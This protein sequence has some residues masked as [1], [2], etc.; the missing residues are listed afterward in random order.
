M[1]ITH[2][3]GTNYDLYPD[4]DIELTRYNPFFNDLGEQSIPVSIPASAKNLQLFGYP[5]RADNINKIASRLDVN[6]QSG[7]F[8]VNGR[9]AILSAQEKGSIETSFYLHDGAFYEKIEDITLSEIF[10]DRKITFNNIDEA[11]SFMYS[12]ISGVDLRFATF[13]VTTENHKLNAVTDQINA[14][15][16]RKFVNEV[17]TEETI[18]DKKVTIPKGFYLTPFIKVRHLLQEVLTYLG[19]QLG[20]SFL[21]QA[22][23]NEMVFLNNNIDTMLDNSIAY[24]DVIP[25]ITVKTLFNVLRKFNVEF[26]PNEHTKTLNV[27]AFNDSV[28]LTP[29]TD[30][31]SFSVSRKIVKYHDNYR[32]IRLSSETM[33]YASDRSL[34]PNVDFFPSMS[35]RPNP[36]QVVSDDQGLTLFEIIS[37]Y[38]T[39]YL[40]K[41]DGAVVRDGFQGDRAFIDKMAG[42]GIGYYAGGNLAT[43]EFK[44]PD[45]IP[46]IYT[47]IKV[48]YSGQT[49][50]YTYTTFPFVG[51]DRALRSKIVFTDGAEEENDA[52]DLKAMICLF[53]RKPSHCIGVL[54]NYDNSG[55]KLWNNSLLWNGED[56][57]FEK[58][59]R[60]RDTLLRNALLE[61]EIDTILPE[62]LKQSI[63]AVKPL[64]LQ[65]Q[66]YLLHQLQ[67]STKSRSIAQCT[68]FTTKLQEPI[69]TAKPMSESFRPKTHKWVLKYSQTW[70]GA[71]RLLSTPVAFYP[72]DPTPE[73]YASG[74]QYHGRTYPVEFGSYNPD[75][76]FNVTQTGTIYV[77]LEPALY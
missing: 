60:Q 52:S 12:L 76:T 77:W 55:D 38:P 10:A 2:P 25:N 3:S 32:Q 31:S 62:E 24:I 8:S 47:E 43:E 66:K 41:Q 56:G 27:V 68:L 35:I 29:D 59:W 53:Y 22:P 54:N 11:I 39:S 42:I 20:S 1:K 44:F 75:G 46:D 36:D 6:I 34:L 26:I 37:Q 7:S 45:F 72:P 67:Y 16:L 57:I 14:S 49:A 18:D 21:D 65:N 69:S 23:F 15:G 51:T 58:F 61:V 30:L 13:P 40:R 19:Y 73:Q 28:N 74:G 48:T 17:Q 64:L 4:T 70:P 5:E 9:Q 50:I 33:K 71:Y 63:S